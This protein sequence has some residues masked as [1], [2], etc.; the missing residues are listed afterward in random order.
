ML[1]VAVGRGLRSGFVSQGR[2][3][4]THL[5]GAPG[6][7]MARSAGIATDMYASAVRHS[8]SGNGNNL[9]ENL[10]IFKVGTFTDMFGFEQTW[11]DI[12]LEQMVQHFQLLR[13]GGYFPNVPVRVGHTMSVRDVVGYFDEI[14]RDPDDSQ[15]LSATIEFTEPDAWEKWERGT[16]RSR[17]IEI[18]MYETND[19]RSFWP[20]VMGLAFVD[21]PAVEGLHARQGRS[22]QFN[23]STFVTDNEEGNMFPDLNI[24]P[25]GWTQ[26]VNAD[27][28]SFN[29]AAQYAAWITSANY[30]QALDN[31]TN[32]VNYAAA[33]EAEA[34]LQ[35]GT[36]ER[37]QQQ[38]SSAQHSVRA[39]PMMF[40]VNGQQTSDFAAIQAHIDTLETYRSESQDAGRREFVA[41]L[42]REN[43]IS[44]TQIDGLA[45]HVL[46]LNDAQFSSFRKMYEDAPSLPGFAHHGQQSG[47]NNFPQGQQ[48][49]DGQPIID[50]QWGG[51]PSEL[52]TTKEIVAQHRR[53]GMSEDKIRAT[54]SFKKLVAAGIETN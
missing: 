54:D 41:S 42:A 30:A 29:R 39:Q 20:V 50:G 18:G 14:Y 32:A 46:T 38:Q 17:S 52:E 1:A 28:D 40:R 43:K 37:Q 35:Q 22:P 7:T 25:E 51:E 33:L 15:F 2:T 44:A 21:I 45:G 26:A 6:A 27:L 49:S 4:A 8:V 16:W 9:L 13:D 5:F 3:I 11:D 36:Q 12:H 31:W 48:N 19:G 53:S 10:R 23:F 47:M 34:N 24:D